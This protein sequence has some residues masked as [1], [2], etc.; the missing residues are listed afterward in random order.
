MVVGN[1][2]QLG[3]V[4]K[5]Q[6]RQ[7]FTKKLDAGVLIKDE[8]VR[9]RYEAS[10]EQKLRGHQC[11]D[12]IEAERNFVKG[13]N[14]QTSQAILRPK[15]RE[16]SGWTTAETLMTIDAKQEAWVAL[17]SALIALRSPQGTHKGAMDE[18]KRPAGVHERKMGKYCREKTSPKEPRPGE[19]LRPWQPP[20]KE[21]KKKKK[22]SR[23]ATGDVSSTTRRRPKSDHL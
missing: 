15:G 12:E 6:A 20:W 22:K 21:M 7:H 10:L 17:R 5:L 14:Q 16:C 8:G 4:R 2:R 11:C 18:R 1:F 13:A 3:R 23:A 9:A 19:T